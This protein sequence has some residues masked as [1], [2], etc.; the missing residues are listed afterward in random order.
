M[1]GGGGTRLDLAL[2]FSVRSVR[3]LARDLAIEA[4]ILK[5][6]GPPYKVLEGAGQMSAPPRITSRAF[7][8]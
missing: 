4:E 5:G 7:R 8:M 6:R 1:R 2:G 3:S